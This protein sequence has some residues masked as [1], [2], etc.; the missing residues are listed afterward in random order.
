MGNIDE[1][2]LSGL[3]SRIGNLKSE[4]EAIENEIKALCNPS[5]SESIAPVPSEPIDI[6]ISDIDIAIVP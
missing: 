1:K 3:L 2:A 5:D 6:S 4:L